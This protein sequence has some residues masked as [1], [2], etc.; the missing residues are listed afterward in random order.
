MDYNYNMRPTTELPH[1]KRGRPGATATVAAASA[2]FLA[3]SEQPG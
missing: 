3:Y 1:N 2:A